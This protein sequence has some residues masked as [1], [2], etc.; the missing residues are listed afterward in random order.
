MCDGD[1]GRRC[2]RPG[3]ATARLLRRAQPRERG[4]DVRAYT[5]E[6]IG[7]V[8]NN[9]RLVSLG[10]PEILRQYAGREL[11][12]WA[13]L[14][15]KY[16]ITVS[17]TATVNSS[18]SVRAVKS[19]KSKAQP[20]EKLPAYD[21]AFKPYPLKRGS[22]SDPLDLRSSA[23]DT[24]QALKAGEKTVALLVQGTFPLDNIQKCRHLVRQC[25]SV[26]LSWASIIISCRSLCLAAASV[27]SVLP[28]ARC[29]SQGA[30]ES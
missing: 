12:L 27:G 7:Y 24:L 30:S 3:D 14:H 29:N 25:H 16:G 11:K 28:E 8:L 4:Q 23:F 21:A 9:G 18:S 17:A 5:E 10:S 26:S 20:S 1:V 19:D 6:V 2:R 13:K 15:K 22:D